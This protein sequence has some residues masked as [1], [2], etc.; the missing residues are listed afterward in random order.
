MVNIVKQNAKMSTTKNQMTKM[1]RN[2]FSVLLRNAHKGPKDQVKSPKGLQLEVGAL[3]CSIKTSGCFLGHR[4]L[5]PETPIEKIHA[6][7][8]TYITL[9]IDDTLYMSEINTLSKK[10]MQFIVL[11]L[12]R[13]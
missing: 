5:Q 2:P 12:M 11:M 9:M 1:V 8:F 4:S 7:L 3:Q 13:S 6:Q 10:E